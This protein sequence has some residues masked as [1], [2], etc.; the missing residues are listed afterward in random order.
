MDGEGT[1]EMKAIDI[2][3]IRLDGGTQS[4]AELDQDVIR[5]YAELK[6][7]QA[8]I[9]RRRKMSDGFIEMCKAGII[10]HISAPVTEQPIA[11]PPRKPYTAPRVQPRSVRKQPASLHLYFPAMPMW[12]LYPDLSA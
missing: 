5:D 11:A 4:R 9:D 2:S 7:I 12:S 1:A 3:K 10:T 6:E 8:R